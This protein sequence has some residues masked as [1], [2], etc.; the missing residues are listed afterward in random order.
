MFDIENSIGFLLAK[1]YQRGYALFKKPLEE[2]A[3]TPKQFSLLAFL[4]KQDGLSQ[5]E[6]SEK[7][8][9]DRTTVGG[10]LDRLEKQGYVSRHP[11]PDDRRA[12]LIRLTISG[13]SLEKELLAIARE[14]TDIFA[15]KLSS[16]DILTLTDLL[17]KLRY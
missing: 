9:I 2:Y 12:Y 5:I 11:H 7:C 13:K 4:W 14:V 1:A 17:R 10:L 3:L 16:E 6:L 8:Q 15:A